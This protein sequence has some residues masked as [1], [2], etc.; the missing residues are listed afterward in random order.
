MLVSG[1][2][3]GLEIKCLHALHCATRRCLSCNINQSGKI[4]VADIAATSPIN[5]LCGFVYSATRITSTIFY[6]SVSLPFSFSWNVFYFPFPLLYPPYSSLF[7]FFY[8]NVILWYDII[9]LSLC[10]RKNE[11]KEATS[12]ELSLLPS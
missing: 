11:H 2:S 3:T 9:N 8:V 6:N 1:G 12:R 7:L 4:A 5:R 10:Q